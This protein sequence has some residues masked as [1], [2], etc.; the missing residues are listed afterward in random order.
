MLKP[1]LFTAV[2]AAIVLASEQPVGEQAR[3]LIDKNPART[4]S[5]IKSGNLTAKVT[6]FLSEANP[7]G[8]EVLINYV[9]KVSFV[10]SQE[11]QQS[12]KIDE[13]FFKKSFLEDL[14][15]NHHYE[16]K[17]FKADH[18]GYADAKNLDGKV[19]PH[20]DKVKMYDIQQDGPLFDLAE[21]FLTGGDGGKID[22]LVVIAHIYP[23][24]PVLGGAKVDMSGDYNRM[25]VK[26]GGDYINP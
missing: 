8:Y 10:G 25:F 6:Q 13:A 26:A 23:T 20:C 5:L 14:R 4:T 21:E 2:V 19:Y 16:G 3:Y 17:D 22:N 1:I 7:P 9:F 18:L 24:V 15:K 11:G 12:A